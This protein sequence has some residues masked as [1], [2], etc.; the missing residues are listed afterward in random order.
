MGG[1]KTRGCRR[2]G[3]GVQMKSRYART[4]LHRLGELA[5]IATESLQHFGGLLHLRQHSAGDVLQ[6]TAALVLVAIARNG[7]H[8]GI[9]ASER[10]VN[11]GAFQAK[12]V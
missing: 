2:E 4:Y 12:S 8:A 1:D 5:Q 9:F 6:E 11:V 3:V 10:L 7:G